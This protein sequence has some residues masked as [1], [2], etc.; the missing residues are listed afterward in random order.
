MWLIRKLHN[1]LCFPGKTMKKYELNLDLRSITYTYGDRC[2]RK[3]TC[4]CS[5]VAYTYSR[6]CGQNYFRLFPREALFATS[7]ILCICKHWIIGDALELT[8]CLWKWLLL[9]DFS[10]P[11]CLDRFYCLVCNQG[12]PILYYLLLFK[13]A[14]L[15]DLSIYLLHIGTGI[16]SSAI[17][18]LAADGSLVQTGDSEHLNELFIVNV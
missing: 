15:V 16:C 7:L 1:N 3:K 14:C 2:P 11:S 12:P 9:L 13:N 8:I 18:R 17:Y 4:C 10:C 5:I 6:R